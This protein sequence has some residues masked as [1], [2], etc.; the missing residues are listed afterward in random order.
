MQRP[1]SRLVGLRCCLIATRQVRSLTWPMLLSS[2]R[3]LCRMVSNTHDSAHHHRSFK[4]H[5]NFSSGWNAKTPNKRFRKSRAGVKDGR[6]ALI[7]T[8]CYSSA[9]SLIRSHLWR[10]YSQGQTKLSS[11]VS[12][13]AIQKKFQSLCTSTSSKSSPYCHQEY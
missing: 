4:S 2:R 3:H 10:P 6:Y 8:R 12:S 11:F 9:R 1:L 7:P 5:M 13:V